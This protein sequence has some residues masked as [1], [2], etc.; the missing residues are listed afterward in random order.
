MF[1]PQEYLTKSQIHSLF[2]RMLAAQKSGKV[3]PS[4]VKE[5]ED[6]TKEENLNDKVYDIFSLLLF[7]TCTI[8]CVIFEIFFQNSGIETAHEIQKKYRK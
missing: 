4:T 8:M 2:T 5:M 7:M 6:M 1:T 3:Q